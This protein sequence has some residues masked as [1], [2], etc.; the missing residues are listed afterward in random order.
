MSIKASKARGV[1]SL[2]FRPTIKEKAT[3]QCRGL[4]FA[5]F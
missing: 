3:V 2:T 4:F 1:Q 5:I